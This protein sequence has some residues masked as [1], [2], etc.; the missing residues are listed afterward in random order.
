MSNGYLVGVTFWVLQT[1]MEMDWELDMGTSVVG[2]SES[3][4]R[5]FT[6]YGGNWGGSPTGVLLFFSYHY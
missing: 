1:L 4:T 6:Y 3:S 2:K 5:V